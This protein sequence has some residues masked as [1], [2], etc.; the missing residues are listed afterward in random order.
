M[1]YGG[2][3]LFDVL[4]MYSERC[5]LLDVCDYTAAPLYASVKIKR[6]SAVKR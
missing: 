5:A 4:G 2:G 1:C 3:F 6:I